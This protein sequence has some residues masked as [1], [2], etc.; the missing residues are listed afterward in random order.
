MATEQKVRGCGPPRLLPRKFR[1][2][3]SMW[4]E[5]R[6]EAKQRHNRLGTWRSHVREDEP[7]LCSA[8]LCCSSVPGPMPDAGKGSGE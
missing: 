8:A 1:I 4:R 5:G 2:S 6:D 3:V 7:H